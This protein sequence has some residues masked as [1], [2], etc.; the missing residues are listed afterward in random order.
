M[1][2]FRYKR[3]IDKEED[4][5]VYYSILQLATVY[6]L[7]AFTRPYYGDYHYPPAAIGVGWLIAFASF[8]PIPLCAVRELT[9]HQGTLLQVST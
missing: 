4:V 6:N 5:Q 2:C 3:S 8:I 7:V 9:R 1:N